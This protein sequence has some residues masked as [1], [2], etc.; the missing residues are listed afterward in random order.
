MISRTI[1]NLTLLKIFLIAFLWAA[2]A[3]PIT[4]A[5]G[6]AYGPHASESITPV[7]MK[8]ERTHADAS[9]PI[10]YLVA[11]DISRDY[12]YQAVNWNKVIW[13]KI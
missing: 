7:V 6:S 13:P 11:L 5:S 8:R 12:G 1:V 4:P 10:S 9:D 2:A 3:A